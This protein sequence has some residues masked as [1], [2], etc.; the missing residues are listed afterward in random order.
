MKVGV[1]VGPTFP[2]GPTCQMQLKSYQCDNFL[3]LSPTPPL[4]KKKKKNYCIEIKYMLRTIHSFVVWLVL[5]G[6][7]LFY[8]I[9]FF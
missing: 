8:F 6:L 4:L 3:S 2:E 9:L 1:Y 5:G 7:L